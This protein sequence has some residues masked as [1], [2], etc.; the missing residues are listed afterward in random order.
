VKVVVDTNILVSALLRRASSP[1]A[2]VLDALLA[3]ELTLLY[4]ERILAEYAEVL[5]REKFGFDRADVERLL[6]FIRSNGR[7]W[8]TV[9]P[10][11]SGDEALTE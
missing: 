6:A 9:P 3:G 11:R 2:R 4:D 1:P 10:P 8:R 5:G 7:R